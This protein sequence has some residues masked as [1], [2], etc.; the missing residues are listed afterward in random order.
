VLRDS[1]NDNNSRDDN[2]IDDDDKPIASLKQPA[3]QIQP[4]RHSKPEFDGQSVLMDIVSHF[5]NSKNNDGDIFLE[6]DDDE[7]KYE[8][9]IQR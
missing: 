1:R 8:E 2:N 9:C 5:H 6:E 4:I 7:F 3:R